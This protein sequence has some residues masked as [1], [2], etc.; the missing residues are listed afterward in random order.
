[1]SQHFGAFSLGSVR[2][3]FIN[4]HKGRVHDVAY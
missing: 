1:M 4:I 2:V 3:P